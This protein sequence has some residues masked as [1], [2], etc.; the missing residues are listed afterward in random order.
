MGPVIGSEHQ[1]FADDSHQCVILRRRIR[2]TIGT[3]GIHVLDHYGAILGSIALPQLS[4]VDPIVG[5]QEEGIAE[6]YEM[7]EVLVVIGRIL[8]RNILDH[9]GT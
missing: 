7:V 5:G 6:G 9:H 8:P 1:M 4:A 2:K 3:T